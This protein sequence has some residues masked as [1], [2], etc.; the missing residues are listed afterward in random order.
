MPYL[1]N[2]L[3]LKNIKL[4]ILKFHSEAKS[5]NITKSSTQPSISTINQNT[6]NFPNQTAASSTSI[7]TMAATPA[8]AASVT[9]NRTDTAAPVTT[10][11]NSSQSNT[12]AEATNQ[13]RY[14]L[15]LQKIGS[16][17][18]DIKYHKNI[19]IKDD[20]CYN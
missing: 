7:S 17:K 16:F 8:P 20:F 15:K 12:P 11:S 9:G 1:N 3:N 10:N 18:F 19:R 13:V 14:S 4:I 5:E 2:L 6:S